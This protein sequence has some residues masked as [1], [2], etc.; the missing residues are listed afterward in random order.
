MQNKQLS[1]FS[2]T[3]LKGLA[4]D[5]LVQRDAINSQLGAVNQAID[6]RQKEGGTKPMA[7]VQPEQENGSNKSNNKRR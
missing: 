2:L 3:E 5:L 4:Y 7:V 1:D 6:K